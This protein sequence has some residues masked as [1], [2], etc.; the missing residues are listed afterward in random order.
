MTDEG[1][2]VT[3]EGDPVDGDHGFL[4]QQRLPLVPWMRAVGQLFHDGQLVAERQLQPPH[5]TG[6]GADER[7]R[8]RGRERVVAWRRRVTA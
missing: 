5:V 2:D 3:A 4:S 8:E 1:L 6:A 7:E